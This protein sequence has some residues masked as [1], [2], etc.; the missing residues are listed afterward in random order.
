T[1]FKLG[2]ILLTCLAVGSCKRRPT[3]TATA[4]PV[5]VAQVTSQA[6]PLTREAVGLVQPLH[7]VAIQSRVDGVIAHVHFTEGDEV[8]AGTLLITLDQ[9]PFQNALRSAQAQLAQARANDEK[10]EADFQRYSRLHDEKAVSDADFTQYSAAATGARANV[11]VQEAA[12]AAAQLNL[13]YTEIRAPIDGRTSR[14]SQREGGVV[15]ANDSSQPLLILNQMAPIGA[16]FSLPESDLAAVRA[17][18]AAG[19]VPVRARIKGEGHAPVTGR[20]DYLDNT[21][22]LNTGNIALRATFENHD[23]AL[24]PGQF[25]DLSLQ[26]GELPD[27]LVVPATAIVAGQAGNQIF[28]VKPDQTVEVRVAHTGVATGDKVVVLDAVKPGET[29]VTD[30]QL[31][32][33]NGTK[34]TVQTRETD[35]ASE[36]HPPR[37]GK[38]S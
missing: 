18:M 6:V 8:K 29:V 10:A 14:L 36:P 31:R 30:G 37:K 22:G 9:R 11:A 7:T 20:L 12:V 21:V 1:W 5:Y 26:V 16:A 3:T 15:K 32:L 13:D 17:A 19:T 35:T 4:V 34:I 25:V 33:V 27:A 23:G 38:K 24:W 28:V 2:L